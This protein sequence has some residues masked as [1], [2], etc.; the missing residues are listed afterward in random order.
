MCSFQVYMIQVVKDHCSHQEALLADY[1]DTF[2]ELNI[3]L[4]VYARVPGN[5]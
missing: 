1:Q 3:S 4:L 5:V 2:Q